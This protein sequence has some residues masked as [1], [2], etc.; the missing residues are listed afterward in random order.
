MWDFEETPAVPQAPK[1]LV[2]HNPATGETL[3]QGTEADEKKIQA[4]VEAA[5]EAQRRWNLLGLTGRLEIMERFRVA[6]EGRRVELSRLIA[7]ETGKP[8]WDANTEVDAVLGKLKITAE[9]YLKRTGKTRGEAAGV[10]QE[11]RHRPHGVMAVFGPYNFPAHLPNGHIMPALI[12]GNSVVFK[13]S[14]QTPA[15]GEWM[16]RVWQEV[17]LP[18]GVLGV[19]QGGKAVGEALVR[20]PDI[21]G[22]LFTGSYATGKAI[23]EALAGRPDV[24]LALEM[25]GNN[26]LVVW[27]VKDAL[28]AAK[29]AVHSAYISAGQRCTCARRLILPKGR[30]GDEIVKLLLEIIPRLRVG[31]YTD[32]PEPFMG[33]VISNHQASAVVRAEGGLVARGGRRLISLQRVKEEYP[34]LKPGLVDMTDVGEC[35]D[36]EY[37]GPLLQIIRVEDFQVA[38]QVANDTRYGLAAGLISDSFGH[39]KLFHEHIRAGIVNWNRPTTGASSA[40]PFGGVGQSGNLRPAAYYAADY[41]AYPVSSLALE[42]VTAP[43][44]APGMA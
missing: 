31:A 7:Q 29:L 20:H 39:W 33:P 22:V 34:F 14:D 1:T 26:P 2:S 4:V 15:V 21:N 27:D 24:M 30:E 16:A 5:R 38:L 35:P 42:S 12:A 11:V 25:G 3:W 32:T 40:A 37:F 17:G 41:C 28:A 13:P 6:V 44:D 8:L 18:E 10:Q 43:P 36:E 9:A 19:V 23:H